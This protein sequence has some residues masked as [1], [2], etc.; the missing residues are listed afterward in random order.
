MESPLCINGTTTPEQVLSWK[1]GGDRGTRGGGL[2]GYLVL[3]VSPMIFS[4]A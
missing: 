4:F 3:T 2:S 1:N